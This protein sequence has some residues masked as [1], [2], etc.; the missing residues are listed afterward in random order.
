MADTEDIPVGKISRSVLG[1]TV[2]AKAGLKHLKYLS[3]KAIRNS[4]K[5]QEEKTLHEAQLG[6]MLF[7]TLSQLRGTALKVSQILS[8]EADLLPEHVR[9]ELA[10]GCYQVTPLNRALVRKSFQKEFN[11][12]PESLFEKFEPNAF[13]AASLGQVHN[14]LTPDGLP[15][16]VKIQ[17]PGIATSIDSDLKLIRGVLKTLS[18]TTNIM[19]NKRVIET[20]ISEIE[21]RLKEE[22]D[23]VIEA[24]HTQWFADHIKHPNVVIPSVNYEYSSSKIL[25]TKKLDGLHLDEWLATNPTHEERN[26]F[27]QTVFDLFMHSLFDLN[28]FHSDPH[29]GNYL[30]MP[31]GKLG[32]LDFGFVK[33]LSAGFPSLLSQMFNALLTAKSDKDYGSLLSTYKKLH[34]LSPELELDEFKSVL[35]PFLQPLHEW[36]IEPFLS[37]RFDFSTKSPYPVSDMES[38]KPAMGYLQDMHRD[39]I[40]FDRTY[41]GVIRILEKIEATISTKN[42]WIGLKPQEIKE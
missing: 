8:M 12:P 42:Q 35:I 28:K 16:A 41:I 4:N 23:Y 7:N 15:V 11:Q 31:N 30:F 34:M 37:H 5:V 13:A 21:V 14:A 10:K 17:Y 40:Y 32:L 29:P 19:P 22:V 24:E 18:M 1:G 9:S 39:Q 20:V 25:T 33:E 2:I 3:R 36:M 6:K 38:S 27:G 26:H